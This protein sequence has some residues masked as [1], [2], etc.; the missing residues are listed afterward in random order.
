MI[1]DENCDV[2]NPGGTKVKQKSNFDVFLINFKI[3][4]IIMLITILC[5]AYLKYMMPKWL[6]RSIIECLFKRLIFS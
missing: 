6:G 4:L 3:L 5:R 2:Y 1:L